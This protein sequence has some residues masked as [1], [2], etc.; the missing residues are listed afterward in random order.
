[1]LA[2]HK[3]LALRLAALERKTA[4]HDEAIRSVMAAIRQLM[5]PPVSKQRRIGFG[6]MGS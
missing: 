3:G 6:V 4:T 5:A 1:M 2:T